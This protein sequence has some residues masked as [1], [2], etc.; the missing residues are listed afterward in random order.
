MVL[1]NITVSLCHPFFAYAQTGK[2]PDKSRE[3]FTKGNIRLLKLEIHQ[4]KASH[5]NYTFVEEQRWQT[6][7]K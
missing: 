2:K 4:P 3:N 1:I 6:I 5:V 7:A